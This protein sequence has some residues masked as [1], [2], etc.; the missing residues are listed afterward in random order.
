V[1]RQLPPLNA[2]RA[3][4]AAARH[5]SFSRAAEELHVT[6]AAISQ[7]IRHLEEYCGQKLFRRLTRALALTEA[8]AAALPALREGFDRLAEGAERLRRR[9]TAGPLTVSVAP[10]FAAKWLVPRLEGFRTAH[11]DYDIRIDA[12]DDLAR[13]DEDGVDV[14]LRYGLGHYPDLHSECLMSEM[15][16]PVCSPAL[17]D[18]DPPLR[19]PAD[20]RHHTLL[21][22]NWKMEG[23]A[24]PNWRMWLR[25]AG[26]DDVEADRGPQFSADSMAIQ[27]AIEGQGVAL[28]GAVMAAADLR[29]GRLVRPFAEGTGA[30]PEFCYYLVCPPAWAERPKVRAFRDWLVAEIEADGLA[31]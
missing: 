26:I 4:E 19:A 21:H 28:A 29:A 20:L 17:R 31:D 8:G 6:P 23:A 7:Q 11:P 30:A 25:A 1:N 27:A 12:T 15:A 10:S 22:V 14:A 16:F 3:F 9:E 5:L 13:F 24:A 18:G 2:L